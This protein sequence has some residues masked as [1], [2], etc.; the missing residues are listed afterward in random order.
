MVRKRH[1][2]LTDENAIFDEVL[3]GS[4]RAIAILL[5]S[6]LEMFM[7]EAIAGTFPHVKTDDDFE[8]LFGQYRPLSTFAAKVDVGYAVGLF[9]K[10]LRG[11]LDRVRKIRNEFAHDFSDLRFHKSPI[12]EHVH[13]IAWTE[14][15]D[16]SIEVRPLPDMAAERRKFF[17]FT[18]AQIVHFGEMSSMGSL[19]L[20]RLDDDE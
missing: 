17:K 3:G 9:D 15:E 12:K 6:V 16:K 10:K 2:P 18:V 19:K 5:G 8:R 11:N 14:A 4:D 20:T 1:L 7:Q 13:A